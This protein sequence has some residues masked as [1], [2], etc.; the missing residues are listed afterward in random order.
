MGINTNMTN[1]EKKLFKKDCGSR[2]AELRKISHQTQPELASTLFMS[3]STL[4]H[5]EQGVTVPN[6]YQLL[7]LANFFKVPT[8]YLLCKCS[9]A[10]EYNSLS[11]ICCNDL[12][13]NDIVNILDKFSTK[14]RQT[15]IDIILA[16]NNAYYRKY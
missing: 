14:D 10:K 15:V 11:E 3:K 4:G 8:D 1:E 12:S 9:L 7:S 2:I 16:I 13:F 5:F 6:A